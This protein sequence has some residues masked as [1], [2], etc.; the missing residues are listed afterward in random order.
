M[1][2]VIDGRGSKV[3]V[4]IPRPKPVG[5]KPDAD[6]RRIVEDVRLRGD[7]ALFEFTQSL[8]GVRIDAATVRVEPSDIERATKLVPPEVVDALEVTAERLRATCERQVSAGWLEQR[9]D[10][11]VGELVRP[12]RRVGAYVPGGRAAYPSSVIMCAVPARAAGVEQI[13]VCTPPGPGG[14]IPETTLAACAV[15]GV[16][17]VYRV[18]GAQAVAAMAYGT[19]SVRPVQKIVGPGNV[20]VTLAKRLVSEWVGIDTD[21]GPS[22]IAVVAGEGA[23]A[24]EIA[25]DLIAQA[26]HGPLGTH[27]LITWLPELADEVLAEL[28]RQVLQHA[29]SEE[30]EN[31]LIEGGRV[32]LVD[33]QEEALA[34]ADL[35]APEHLELVFPGA[36]DALDEINS[37]GS[38]FVGRYSPVAVGDYAGGTNHVLPSGG[39]ARWSGGLSARD[40][41]KHIYVSGYERSAL[42]RLAPHIEALAGAEGLHGHGASVRIRLER[43]G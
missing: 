36:L 12:L 34:A 29:R 43:E 17:E 41:Q 16:D 40:F 5:A 15:A 39:S 25:A 32:A 1:L 28:D 33:G 38:V 24:A 11:F 14:E 13:A 21:A 35:L 9:G 10:E 20:Y 26:E 7:D 8:D 27:V 4:H 22:E 3:P 31:A 6:V 18:G 19:T 2:E 37:A 42:E 23:V 30:V